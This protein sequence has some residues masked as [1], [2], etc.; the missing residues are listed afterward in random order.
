MSE[1][2][3]SEEV[4]RTTEQEVLRQHDL[5]EA[6]QLT[7][8]QK[9]VRQCSSLDLRLGCLETCSNWTL[10]VYHNQR[11]LTTIVISAYLHLDLASEPSSGGPDAALP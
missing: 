5:E 11:P 6:K 9:Y 4:K 2:E 8:S 7:W 1:E 10:K 3:S